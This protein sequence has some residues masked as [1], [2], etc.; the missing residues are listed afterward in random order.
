MCTVLLPPDVNPTAVNKYIVCTKNST[1]FKIFFNYTLIVIGS[2][3][4]AEPAET[5]V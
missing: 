1:E 3:L 2:Q 4:S 5:F